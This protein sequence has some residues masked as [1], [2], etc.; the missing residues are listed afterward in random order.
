L[1]KDIYNFNSNYGILIMT[2]L[3]TKQQM[4]SRRAVAPVI[5]TLLLVAIAV[6]GGSI[7]FVFSQGF[8]SSAQISGSPQIESIEIT[9][10][11]AT[12]VVELRMHD[13][14]CGGGTAAPNACVVAA[15][16]GLANN[17]LLQGERVAVYVQNQSAQRVTLEEVLLAG[18]TYDYVPLA[19]AVSVNIAAASPAEGEYMIVMR[20]DDGAPAVVSTEVVPTLEA[21]QEATILFELTGGIANGR[22]A[23]FKIETANGA[24]FVGTIIAGQQSG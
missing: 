21:G 17:G 20:G 11:D 9:G 10:Y 15:W 13:G 19:G 6:V 7:I 23:Q 12:D 1:H 5:A 4:T 8:F 18:N 14:V 24:I 2:K 3:H 22:D 16:D